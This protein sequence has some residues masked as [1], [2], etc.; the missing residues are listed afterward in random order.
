MKWDFGEEKQFSLYPSVSL[1]ETP[2]IKGRLRG[3]KQRSLVTC[4]SPVYMGETQENK[5]TP[6]NGPHHEPN[7][8]S[9]VQKKMFRAG[10][11]N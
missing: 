4:I 7:T 5:T 6:Q 11:G 3:E 10:E 2:V 9:T 8:I 1:T